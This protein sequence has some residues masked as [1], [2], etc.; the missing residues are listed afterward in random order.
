MSVKEQLAEIIRRVHQ[1]EL[2]FVAT[3]SAAERAATGAIDAMSAKD[4]V[5]HITA[6]KQRETT[7]LVAV[8]QGETPIG[9]EHDEAAVYTSHEH[10]MWRQV[11]ANADQ[12]SMRF[13]EQLDR[14]DDQDLTTPRRYIWM[15]GKPL[16]SEILIYG[17]WHPAGHLVEYYRRH[18]D[19]ARAGQ[20]YAAIIA[21]LGRD[22]MLQTMQGDGLNLYNLA[23]AYAATGQTDHAIAILPDAL[24]LDAELVGTAQQDADLD[25]IRADPRFQS[26]LR[27]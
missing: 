17:V 8:L 7:R 15:N 4:L 18:G 3:L 14:F 13:M 2:A 24:R 5:A 12:V 9:D 21:A 19:D 6:A 25:A 26:L 27:T 22:D 1:E 23:C 11:E 16:S 20:L 10:D